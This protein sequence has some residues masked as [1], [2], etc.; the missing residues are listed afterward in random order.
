MAPQ[1]PKTPDES[2]TTTENGIALT[3]EEEKLY[4]TR[5]EEGYNLFD[6]QYIKWL[7]QNHPLNI[8][9]DFQHLIQRTLS[10]DKSSMTTENGIA[11]TEEEEK[12]YQTRYEE[13]Y[14]LFDEKY[15][16]WH[17]QIY[18]LN[19]PADFQH[20]IQSTLSTGGPEDLVPGSEPLV[21]SISSKDASTTSP[22]THQTATVTSGSTSSLPSTDV[23]DPGS[24]SSILDHFDDL[25]PEEPLVPEADLNSKDTPTATCDLQSDVSRI[26]SSTPDSTQG[27][28]AE[29]PLLNSTPSS[30]DSSS[31]SMSTLANNNI[32]AV[33]TSTQ[34]LV[35][36]ISHSPPTNLA[37]KPD[38]L[39]SNTTKPV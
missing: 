28:A 35:S 38:F 37:P 30:K 2:T 29:S 18:P 27:A 10:T 6:E 1:N 22:Q 4:Q 33:S 8:P 7:E 9:A 25:L 17:E 5:Y 15:I 26:D 32:I 31:N 3:E 16:K 23:T 20:L 19:I 14:N 34:N 13:G 21:D 24:M 39:H 11:F 12:L 36:N